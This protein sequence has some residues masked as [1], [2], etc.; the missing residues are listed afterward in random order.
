[1][2][3]GMERSRTARSKDG[4]WNEGVMSMT[5]C[6]DQEKNNIPADTLSHAQF[7]ALN[8]MGRLHEIHENLCHLDITSLPHFVKVRNLPYSIE[9]V[10]RVCAACAVCAAC[11]VYAR[12]KSRFYTPVTGRLVKA[13]QPMERL[14]ID[15]MGPLRS[16][17]K[18]RYLLTVINEYS[19]FPFAF[20]CTSTNTDSVIQKL[21]QIFIVFGMLSDIHSDWGT[22]FLSKEVRE[23]LTN[24]G[25]DTSRTTP[26]HPQGNGQCAR[27]N[28][29][30]WKQI[31]L[32]L[33]SRN[34]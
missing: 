33:A 3:E 31:L 8:N 12:W 34:L 17:S 2:Q 27:Y 7:N 15:F 20:A 5:S 24:L 21:N 22:S 13:T 16:T 28:G 6:T 10:N 19:R 23:Y 1:M 9:E 18:N 25:I 26:Y 30:I 11:E 29:I 4:E 32:A 14:S